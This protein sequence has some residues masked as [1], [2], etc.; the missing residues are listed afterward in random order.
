M[1]LHLSDALALTLKTLPFIWLRGALYVAFGIFG[2]LY[3]AVLLW[4]A[5]IFGDAGGIAGLIFLAAT[6]GFFVIARLFRYYVLYLI[7]VAHISVIS[8]LIRDGKLPEGVDQVSFGKQFITDKF[9]DVS[10]LFLVQQTIKGV[11]NSFH[12]LVVSIEQILPIPG[13][14]GVG[15]LVGILVNFS[16]VFVVQAIL[17]FVIIRKQDNVWEGARDGILL[18]AQSWKSILFNSAVYG[19]IN[20]VAF[21]VFF[22]LV[23]AP[24]SVLF[25]NKSLAVLAAVIVAYVLKHALIAPLAMSAII[26]TF[27][28]ETEGKSP[29]PVWKERLESVS[30]KFVELEQKAASYIQ[31]AKPSP[32]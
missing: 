15:K 28:E 11:I 4:L 13:L 18:Y 21:V 25:A 30:K 16:V 22:L 23:A 5:K 7:E 14:D 32:Q 31:G 17:S 8:I 27:H 2:I 12:R 1:K 3:F 20:S 9:K 24:I 26:L 29:D 6:A 19:L 10:I